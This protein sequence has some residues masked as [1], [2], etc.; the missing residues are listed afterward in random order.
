LKE[1]KKKISQLGQTESSH[2]GICKYVCF[3]NEECSSPITQIAFSYL[4]KNEN[5][6]KHSHP[7]LEEVFLILEGECS[8]VID[9]NE[10]TLTS[11]DV[12]KIPPG[13]T[14]EI[15]AKTD[16]KFYYFGVAI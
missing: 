5:V 8:F 4:K 7:T 15:H 2:K 12:V 9:G 6:E 11:F 10:L 16:C 13:S 14:H 1:F 3:T